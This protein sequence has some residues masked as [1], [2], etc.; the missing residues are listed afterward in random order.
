[1][2]LKGHG[3]LFVIGGFQSILCVSLFL[4]FSVPFSTA[5]VLEFREL[6]K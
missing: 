3:L 5:V 6:L 2:G 1:M 4:C